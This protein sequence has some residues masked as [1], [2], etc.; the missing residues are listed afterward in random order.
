MAAPANASA[1][2]VDPLLERALAALDDSGVAW[3]V[4]R[5]ED[6]LERPPHDVDLLVAP[7]GIRAAAAA[8]ADAGFAPLPLRSRHRLFAAYDPAEDRW[9][10][11]DVVTELA[12]GRPPTFRLPV[13]AAV[14]AR[15]VRLHDVPLLELEDRFWTELLHVALDRED[16]SPP[17]ARRLAT[18]AEQIG[19]TS[20]GPVAACLATALGTATRQHLLALAANDDWETLRSFAAAAAG[21]PR[22]RA[23][24]STLLRR[25][26]SRLGRSGVSVALVGPDGAGKSTVAAGLAEG[27]PL[28]SR[29]L[30]MGLQAG[31]SIPGK[32]WTPPANA[33]PR[34]RRRPLPLRLARQWRRLFRLG[35]RSA[36]AW[37]ALTKGELVIFDRFAYD[38]EVHWSNADGPGGRLRRWLIRRVVIRP[39]VVVFL[40]VP[41]EITF[42]R[43]REHSP[44]L[45]ELR[46]QRYLEL[47]ARLEHACVVDGTR[48]QDEVRAKVTA[49]VWAAYARKHERRRPARVG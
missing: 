5:G 21:R 20:D 30:Y 38:A 7:E 49:I 26:R 36:A 28:R 23:P 45:L 47:A 43:K 35:R 11:L 34:R 9:L 41:G 15:R 29:R 4:L 2:S 16:V 12:Y 44:E 17:V 25:L 19:G 31:A 6:Q 14:L 32:T 27:V 48:P 33:A 13:A 8:L 42:A 40:D 10:V 24:G 37:V 46:R 3:C 18:L 1:T 39:D 22:R